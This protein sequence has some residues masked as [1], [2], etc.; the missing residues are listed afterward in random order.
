MAL[1]ILAGKRDFLNFDQWVNDR[2]K[3]KGNE[4]VFYILDYIDKQI[5]QS[6]NSENQ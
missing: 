1:G 6:A 2:I 3:Q 5:I 4:F